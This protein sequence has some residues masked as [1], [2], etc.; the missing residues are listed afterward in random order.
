MLTRTVHPNGV[1]T[2]QSPLLAAAGV[3]HAFSTRIGGVSHG[4]FHTLNLGNPAQNPQG[5]PIPQDEPIYLQS[6]YDRLQ[7]ALGLPQVQRAWVRQVH[8]TRIL[9]VDD[10][11][12]FGDTDADGI[13]TS[14][15]NVLL[16]IRVADCVPI[17][18][19]SA[20]GS[21]VAAV[22]AGWRGVVAGI[23][24][25]A[26]QAL[27]EHGALRGH[28]LAAIGPSIGAPHFEVGEEV[29]AEFLAAGLAAAVQRPAGQPKPHID[30][31]CALRLQLARHDVSHID[32]ADLCT[33]QKSD[34]FF[35]HRRENGITGR[36]AGVIMPR[37]R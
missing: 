36:M 7:D 25:R 17:L 30:L 33:F 6:N 10:P 9:L 3:P 15:K 4:P 22:H 26:V 32:T 8:G 28:L 16:T 1:V 31:A 34:E 11:V 14:A 13:I 29:A 2:Y 12:P 18:L 35:S 37:E 5:P 21:I 19:A 24:P 27:A 23:V 20:D